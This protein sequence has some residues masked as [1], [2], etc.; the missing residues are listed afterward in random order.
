MAGLPQAVAGHRRMRTATGFNTPNAVLRALGP[1]DEALYCALYTDPA[2]MARIGVP[3]SLPAAQRAFATA[4]RR[5]TCPEARERYWA[6][7][8]R[9]TGEVLGMLALIAGSADHGD[10]ELGVMLLPAAQGR[11][12]AREL[13]HAV[14]AHAFSPGGWGLHRLW[15]RHAPGHGAAA[16]VLAASGFRPGPLLGAH[17]TVERTREGPGRKR[18]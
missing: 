18:Q 13:N 12:L 17:A 6:V 5:N 10:V 2:V 1:G 16:A 14:V 9:A 3:L 7:L 15:A 11:G 4:C 8:D